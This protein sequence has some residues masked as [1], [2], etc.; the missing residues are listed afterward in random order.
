VDGLKP[1]EVTEMYS[2]DHDIS[3][4]VAIGTG[5]VSDDGLVI[6]S[7]P[8][9][10]VLKAGWHCG[11]N[12]TR[13]G[14]AG[15]CKTCWKCQGNSCTRYSGPL[16]TNQIACRPSAA[17]QLNS[18]TGTP[19]RANNG[20]P[21][22]T[23]TG[24]PTPEGGC[25]E[26]K[27]CNNGEI[28]NKPLCTAC[29]P[30]GQACDGQGNCTPGLGLL[31]KGPETCKKLGLRVSYTNQTTPGCLENECGAKIRYDITHITHA[32]DGIDLAGAKLTET[33][34]SDG[35]CGSGTE[36][37][38]GPGC[39]IGPGNVVISIRDPSRP[40]RDTYG[41]C[42]P[43][44]LVPEGTCTATFTQQLFIEHGTSKC[45]AETRK[46]IFTFTKSG[47]KC[48]AQAVRSDPIDTP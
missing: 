22:P 26:C 27:E 39:L 47:D 4:F 15:T 16:P 42:G 29:N 33:V 28:G 35:G 44:R 12:P 25:E 40:C 48:E 31:G 11:G 8:G 5:V 13:S 41:I 7:S 3:A 23:D 37:L 1:R 46:I 18:L 36:V 17:R 20:T 45:L 34:T 14:S 6:R 30:A 21:Q 10:G 19:Q 9:V 24:T 32:C 38:T 2:F 43:S